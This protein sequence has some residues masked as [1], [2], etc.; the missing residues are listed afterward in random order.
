[1][2]QIINKLALQS[3]IKMTDR[4]FWGL[5]TYCLIT[6]ASRGIGR[7]FSIEFSRRFAANSLVVL[8]A[9]S[10]A[11]LLET[12]SL[13]IKA[14]PQVKVVTSTI[15]LGNP[16]SESFL[17]IIRDSLVDVDLKPKDF[18]LSVIVHNVGSVGD[19]SEGTS[20][21]SDIAKWQNYFALNVTS[22]ASLNSQFLKVFPDGSTKWRSIIN[23]TSLAAI[24]PIK[25]MG[26][27]CAGKAAREM[28]FKVLAEEN[29][30]LD[31][32]NYSPGPVDTDMVSEVM[33][34]T[35]DAETKGMFLN[36]KETKTILTVHQTTER[37]I[38][39]LDSG[40]YESGQHVDYYDK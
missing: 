21:M 38:S 35:G 12:K 29:P 25:S 3:H 32:L 20:Q 36:L 22:V 28:F 26:Y 40:K 31:V 10:E 13:I 16:D 8:L 27:Y 6:G 5:R 11:G 15:D 2:I 30:T 24:K 14:N 7:N 19:V 37:I 34:N 39:L 33:R 1:M 17:K 18:E 23:V 9:R 4:E